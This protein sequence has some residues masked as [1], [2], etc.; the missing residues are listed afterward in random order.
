VLLQDGRSIADHQLYIGQ[1]FSEYSKVANANSEHA[2]FPDVRSA[3]EVAIPTPANR[4]IGFP[5]TKFMCAFNEIDMGAAVLLTSVG[6][7]KVRKRAFPTFYTET[8]HFV[9]TG[10]GQS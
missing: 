8:H 1:I 9:K 6:K 4:M 2:W 3:E 7:A 5:Y 10:S